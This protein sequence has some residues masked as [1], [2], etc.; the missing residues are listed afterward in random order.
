MTGASRR[1][2]R[3]V[4]LVWGFSSGSWWWTGRP[5][6]LWFMGSQRVKHDWATEL[7]WTELYDRRKL[8]NVIKSGILRWRDYSGWLGWA[9]VIT[10]VL[11]S[12]R[13]R[14]ESDRRRCD[15]GWD[16]RVTQ[17][18]TGRGP[19]AKKCGQPLEVGKGMKRNSSLETLVPCWHLDF[20]LI[21]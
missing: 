10:K 13:G 14:Q 18:L 1:F 7:N 5:G 4:A 20:I 3:A 2:S 11:I 9:S 15:D 19:Q 8:A 12:R 17:L 16:I 6:M 21:F